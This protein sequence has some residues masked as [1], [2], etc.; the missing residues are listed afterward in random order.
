MQ[1]DEVEVFEMFGGGLPVPHRTVTERTKGMGDRSHKPYGPMLF[2]K[3][4][5]DESI[6]HECAQ[7]T[8]KKR[9]G[10]EIYGHS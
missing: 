10:R 5:L 2:Y 4:F 1:A 9:D 3:G 8:R 6:F 7:E